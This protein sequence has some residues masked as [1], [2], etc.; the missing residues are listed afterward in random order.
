MR[1]RINLHVNALK[2]GN[3]PNP[4]TERQ[5]EMS[6]TIITGVTNQLGN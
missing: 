1:Y 6:V 4:N 3:A 2:F 5:R